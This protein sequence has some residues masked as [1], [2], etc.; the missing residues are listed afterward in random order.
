MKKIIYCLLSFSFLHCAVFAETI[1]LKSGQ[2]VSGKILEQTDQFIRVDAN[3]DVPITFYRDEIAEVKADEAANQTAPSIIVSSNEE[4]PLAAHVTDI[5]DAQPSN[6]P[7]ENVPPSPPAAENPAEKHF[8]WKISSPQTTVYLLGSIHLGKSD[9]Y[10]LAP[11]IEDAFKESVNLV[12]EVDVDQLEPAR[13]QQTLVQKATYVNDNLGNH[14]SAKTRAHLVDVLKKYHLPLDQFSSMKPWY[15]AMTLTIMQIKQLGFEEDQG[16]DQYF[17]RQAK[18]TKKIIGLETLDQQLDF[19]DKI[20]DQDN[21]LAYSLET[22]DENEQLMDQIL[23]AWRT[24]D[25][26]SM[27]KIMVDDILRENPALSGLY[28]SLIYD[29]N[30]TMAQKIS[31]FLGTDKIYFV[32]VGAAHIIGEKGI[33]QLLKEKG[34]KAQQL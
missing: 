23:L 28:Q 15:V 9:M 1:Y 20:S 2:T 24:G 4:T 6:P 21:F 8:L 7:V 22:L 32:I 18:G 27:E 16:I 34:F 26:S 29:R 31:A 13:L 14:L 17:L 12:V 5:S 33:V 3:V 25:S 11:V 30:T 19:L 10:P